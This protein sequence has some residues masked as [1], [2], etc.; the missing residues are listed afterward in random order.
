MGKDTSKDPKN[1]AE[2]SSAPG[3][4]VIDV[5]VWDDLRALQRKAAPGMLNK[6]MGIYIDNSSKLLRTLRSE[7]A[8]GD[9]TSIREAAHGLSSSSASL[10]AVNLAALC[11]ELERMEGGSFQEESAALIGMIQDEFARVKSVLEGELRTRRE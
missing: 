11:R 2:P 3:K 6:I 1:T 4:G 7:D 9:A 5:E 10:G 8:V